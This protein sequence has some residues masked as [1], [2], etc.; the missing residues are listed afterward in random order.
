MKDKGVYDKNFLDENNGEFTDLWKLVDARMKS[1]IDKGSGCSLKQ[2]DPILPK[3]KETLWQK[4][5]F[6]K[7]S[8]EQLQHTVFF[9]ACKVFGLKGYDEH[10]DLQFEQFTIGEDS[11]GR[12]I[13]FTERATKTYK[14]GLGH[15]NVQSKNLKHHRQGTGAWLITSSC[16]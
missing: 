12:F 11:A 3:H 5:V 2:A 15:L 7:E 1:F 10:H 9:N 4:H 14:G 8:A 6:G 13:Q 16:I